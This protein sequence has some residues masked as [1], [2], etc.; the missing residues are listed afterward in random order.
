MISESVLYLGEAL[1]CM[2]KIDAGWL[3]AGRIQEAP[4]DS[5][6]AGR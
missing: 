1:T 3:L 2:G 4:E 5:R 6:W